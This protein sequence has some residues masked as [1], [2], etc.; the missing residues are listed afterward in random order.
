MLRPETDLWAPLAFTTP[1]LASSSATIPRRHR[2][3]KDGVTFETAQAEMHAPG[4]PPQ[5]RPARVDA[6]DWD[7]ALSPLSDR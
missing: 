4:P 6:G 1:P 3:L 5:G 7:L 2:R